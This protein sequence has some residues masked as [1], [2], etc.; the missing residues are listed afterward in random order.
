MLWPTDTLLTPRH[1]HGA[2]TPAEYLQLQARWIK[3]GMRRLPALTWRAPWR[4]PDPNP[5]VFVESGKWLVACP[6][7]NCPSVDPGWRLACCFECGAIY[8]NLVMPSDAAAI[9]AALLERP[10]PALRAW[11]PGETAEDLRAQ[12]RLMGAS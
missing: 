9:Q 1:V 2:R 6:C 5:P 7:G 3:E 8:D 12:A 10:H 4:A 11:R